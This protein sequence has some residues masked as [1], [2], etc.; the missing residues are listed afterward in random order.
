M[1]ELTDELIDITT[2][3][4]DMLLTKFKTFLGKFEPKDESQLGK[5]STIK[6]KLVGQALFSLRKHLTEF[7][8]IT[9][10]VTYS[11][12]SSTKWETLLQD[13]KIFSSEN[14]ILASN[15]MA[16]FWEVDSTLGINEIFCGNTHKVS[17]FGIWT[18]GKEL[19]K[20][21][22]LNMRKHGNGL[23]IFDDGSM[24]E[25]EFNQGEPAL[26]KWKLDTGEN[27]FGIVNKE[28]NYDWGNGKRSHF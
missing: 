27:F 23:Q 9:K 17:S 12:L 8:S 21:E 10:R 13:I 25:G 15:S 4:K 14:D 18:N 6:D 7:S 19:Y 16:E 5:F 22:F 26:G 20:G 11:T 3:Y 28:K 24:F 2:K 1:E